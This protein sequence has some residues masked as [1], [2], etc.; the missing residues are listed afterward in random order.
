MTTMSEEP[1]KPQCI[2]YKIFLSQHPMD[3]NLEIGQ[4]GPYQLVV[5]DILPSLK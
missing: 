4:V 1:S 2:V 5:V 3:D